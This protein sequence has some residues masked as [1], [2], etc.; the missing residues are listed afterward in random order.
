MRGADDASFFQSGRWTPGLWQGA[1]Q[2]NKSAR[3]LP[4][5]NNPS[6]FDVT[7]WGKRS[8]SK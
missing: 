2:R 7:F 4:E 8:L 5:D 1:G 6:T 3:L